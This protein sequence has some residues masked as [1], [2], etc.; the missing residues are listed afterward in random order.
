MHIITTCYQ[1]VFSRLDGAF[2]E[3]IYFLIEQKSQY[4]RLRVL[5]EFM[6]FFKQ[7][8]NFL[9]ISLL[10]VIL[11]CSLLHPLQVKYFF[12][13]LVNQRRAYFK[14]NVQVLRKLGKHRQ[15]VTLS[16]NKVFTTFS[17]TPC[18]PRAVNKAVNIA[19]S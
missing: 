14:L 17:S 4:V 5:S 3:A 1:T 7:S 19:A 13:C 8:I 18:S 15:L 11:F 6:E 2:I 16:D 9:V 10:F 12:L